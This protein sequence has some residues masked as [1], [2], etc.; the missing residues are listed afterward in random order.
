MLIEWATL[1]VT[2]GIAVSGGL[3]GVW[4]WSRERRRDREAEVMRAATLYLNP[5]L[6]A[7][8]DLQS[9]LYNILERDGLQALSSRYPGGE[10]ARET[11]YLF[12]QYFAHEQLLL[13][14]TV[15]GGD[16]EVRW[17]VDH[18]RED[19]A[20]DAIGLDEWCMFRHTQRQLGR[21]LVVLQ[22]GPDGSYW[23]TRS[24]HDFQ[25]AL[26]EGLAAR[27][28]L[29]DA[30]DRLARAVKVADLDDVTVHR[31]CRAQRDLVALLEVLEARMAL[32][33]ARRRPAS[34]RRTCE[35]IGEAAE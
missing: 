27:L 11:L 30:L 29:A 4:T 15:L 1:G 16:P 35:G 25:R 21:E 3:W 14:F 18:V 9:R 24:L 19:L 23:E 34:E 10:Y 32:S 12:G 28:A 31:W 2:L 22:P 20:T 5:L 7:A 6:I 17:H 13:R 33:S 26:D 8:E